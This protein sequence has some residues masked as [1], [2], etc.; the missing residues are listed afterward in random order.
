MSTQALVAAEMAKLVDGLRMQLFSNSEFGLGRLTG[1]FAQTDFDGSGNVTREDFNDVLNYCGL[2]LSEQN[3]TVVQKYFA[4]NPNECKI[5]ATIPID[6]FLSEM[7]I[8][9]SPRRQAIVNKA[10]ASLGG[11]D[12]IDTRSMVASFN[13]AGHTLVKQGTHTAEN[14]LDHFTNGFE[15]PTTGKVSTRS[16]LGRPSAV[17]RAN[18]LASATLYSFCHARV[19]FFFFFLHTGTHVCVLFLRYVL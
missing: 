16:D 6:G 18:R 15:E 1:A 3:L 4:Q 17:A 8:T 2:F 13:A 10:W 19:P 11:G 7:R 14:I 5:T 12:A 9:L